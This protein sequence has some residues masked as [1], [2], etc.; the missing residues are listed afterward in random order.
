MEQKKKV[1]PSKARSRID[2][3][4]YYSATSGKPLPADL[5][6]WFSLGSKKMELYVNDNYIENPT[7]ASRSEEHIASILLTPEQADKLIKKTVAL[8]TSVDPG[9]LE[10]YGTTRELVEELYELLESYAGIP[11]PRKNYS[12]SSRKPDVINE[13]VR[14]RQAAYGIDAA[15]EGR[16]REEAETCVEM[17]TSEQDREQ[18]VRHHSFYAFNDETKQKKTF[19]EKHT[20]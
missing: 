9:E 8:K 6:R 2:N 10:A 15:L 11:R 16:L 17:T 7:R 14:V 13:L 1:K 19:V 5:M 4:K 18:E 20:L 12:K 3:D